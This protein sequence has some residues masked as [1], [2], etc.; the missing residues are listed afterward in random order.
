MLFEILLGQL[1]GKNS[2]PLKPAQG[3]SRS[4]REQLGGHGHGW[5]DCLGVGTSGSCWLPRHGTGLPSTRRQCSLENK[6]HFRSPL[7]DKGPFSLLHCSS[8]VLSLFKPIVQERIYSFSS[9][10]RLQEKAGS[11]AEGHGVM[12]FCKTPPALPPFL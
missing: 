5:Q 4:Q 9:P 3:F 11:G 8:N 12:L 6:T 7:V 2:V 10:T 1:L